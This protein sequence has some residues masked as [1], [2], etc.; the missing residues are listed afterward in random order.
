[1]INVIFY[2]DYIKRKISQLNKYFYG[3]EKYSKCSSIINRLID[4]ELMDS[5]FKGD[6]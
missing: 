4:W 1:M 2:K 6:G 3:S 5:D